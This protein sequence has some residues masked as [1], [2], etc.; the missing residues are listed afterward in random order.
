MHIERVKKSAKTET[1]INVSE[2]YSIINLPLIL[3]IGRL[4]YG[5]EVLRVDKKRKSRVMR[6]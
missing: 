1:F 5:S 4:C 6:L 2:V 3:S